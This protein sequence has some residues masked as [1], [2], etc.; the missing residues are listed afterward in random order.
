[1]EAVAGYRVGAV[2]HVITGGGGDHLGQAF[3]ILY[4]SDGS[5]SRVDDCD[6]GPGFLR[7][8][9]LHV[10]TYLWL[11]ARGGIECPVGADDGELP[12][13]PVELAGVEHEPALVGEVAG[14]VGQEL[15]VCG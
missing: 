14:E 2:F 11:M 8:E 12:A 13:G 10:E 1:M 3:V 6:I 9:D 5:S 7:L 15:L 4:V